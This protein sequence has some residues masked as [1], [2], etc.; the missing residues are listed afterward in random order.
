MD[1]F[2]YFTWISIAENIYSVKRKY[3]ESERKH[4]V[5]KKSSLVLD[6]FSIFNKY[7]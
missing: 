3:K 2:P 7:L 4:E 6:Y 1:W 5:N